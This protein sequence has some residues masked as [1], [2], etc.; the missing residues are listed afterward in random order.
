M[1]ASK[2]KRYLSGPD[3]VICTL[4][5]MMKNSGGAGNLSQIVI[6]LDTVIDEKKAAEA[7]ENFV[8]KFPVLY[9]TVARDLRL[10]PFW[11][12]PAEAPEQDVLR[13]HHLPGA[14]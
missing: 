10:A 13:V 8:R 3:W 1:L 5:R 14:G 2:R 9:G 4:D 7:L 6:M 11:K 12:I